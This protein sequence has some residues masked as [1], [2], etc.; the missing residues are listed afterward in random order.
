MRV[1]RVRLLACLMGLSGL[2]SETLSFKLLDYAVGSAPTVVFTV[3]ATFLVGMGSGSLLSP[4]IA[5]PWVA[6]AT[7]AGVN[8]AWLV[9]FDPILAANGALVR[10]LTP[11]LGVNLSASLLAFAYVAPPALLLGV[12]FPALVEKRSDVAHPYV[13]QALGSIAGV[14]VVEVVLFPSLGLP[15][16][17]WFLCA[18]HVILAALLMGDDFRMARIPI[19]RPISRLLAVG[20][21][22]G[23]LQGIWLFLAQLLFQPFYFVQPAVVATML[24]G[25]FL[26][27]LLWRRLRLPFH[28]VL[29]YVLIGVALS[30]VLATAWLAL[31][32]SASTLVSVAE[33]SLIL[34]PAAIPVGAIVPSYFLE[35]AADR[36][37]VGAAWFAI[38][39]GNA[40]GIMVA[41]ALLTRLLSP[42]TSIALVALALALLIA[43]E[44]GARRSAV[45][46]LPLGATL[47]PSIWVG[48]AD[49]IRRVPGHQGRAIVLEN[50]FRGPGELAAVYAFLSPRTG[51]K[52]RRIY[53]TG[54]SPMY[55]DHSPEGL[56]SAVGA[57]Y[58]PGRDRAL[59]LGAGSGRSARAAADVFAHADVVD[60]AVTVPPLLEALAKENHAVL[61][62]ANVSYHSIDAIHAPY[63]FK[64]SYDLIVLTVDPAF[65]ARAAKLYTID[66][67]ARLKALLRPGGVFIFW[68]D[69]SL[70]AEAN[71][72][73]INT[74]KA[75]FREQKLFAAHPLPE[76]GKHLA[77]YFLI[78][79]EVALLYD[80]GRF[81]LAGR[82]SDDPVVA[83]LP[84]F[85]AG[86][87][88]LG[89]LEASRLIV[90]R[91]HSTSEVHTFSHP[92]RSVLLG[93]YHEGAVPILR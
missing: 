1:S 54:F 49:F 2:G 17:L 91:A 82:L 73:L 6:E 58:A 57:A 22:T 48:D 71:Q 74:G 79:S 66:Y 34:L 61:H 84:G 56:I 16:C 42:M 68:A 51:M 20:T 53:Q 78:H 43:R 27:S 19:G 59:V 29:L 31:P 89:A 30:S 72:V 76:K 7:L 28:R 63:A 65:H 15:G 40:A 36:T 33:L 67:L 3:V 23:A 55:L 26:G 14:A 93:G 35:R 90:G 8:L 52:E 41:G 69:S 45:T 80:P 13:W 24:A 21:A 46:L 83:S 12:S 75:V 11:W 9:F 37:E 64:G 62:R 92:S 50:V 86:G 60:L 38:A 88:D 32:Q 5:R 81:G 47:V 87:R 25:L 44:I 10:T 70:G 4:R 85:E 39:L 18:A 77:Y